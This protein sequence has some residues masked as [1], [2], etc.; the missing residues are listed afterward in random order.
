MSNEKPKPGLLVED[1]TLVGGTDRETGAP[2]VRPKTPDGGADSVTEATDPRENR[3]HGK[4]E[5][6]GT[7]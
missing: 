2:V 4:E 1:E 5:E 6:G 3:A 7:S